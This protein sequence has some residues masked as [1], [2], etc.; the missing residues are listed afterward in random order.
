MMQ[1]LENQNDFRCVCGNC[2]I[3]VRLYGT[4]QS[5]HNNDKRKL[6]LET[7]RVNCLVYGQSVPRKYCTIFHLLRNAAEWRFSGHGL[8]LI[9]K[10][11][12]WCICFKLLVKFLAYL[13]TMSW[14]VMS[15]TDYYYSLYTALIIT[16]T[17][18]N[19]VHRNWYQRNGNEALFPR[20]Q[21]SKTSSGLLE[22]LK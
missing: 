11:K 7:A 5:T 1:L 18:K 3:M 10:R 22:F 17:K 9:N 6:L 14:P 21:A 4:R 2:I 20:K 13:P 15:H 19:L 16:T 12:L 8:C